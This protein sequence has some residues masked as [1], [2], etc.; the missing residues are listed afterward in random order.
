MYARR[1][2]CGQRRWGS[3]F[4]PS[5]D[6]TRPNCVDRASSQSLSRASI[7]RSRSSHNS[8]IRRHFLDSITSRGLIGGSSYSGLHG[9]LS[10]S[11]KSSQLRVYSS[12]GDG[13]NT[14]EE[15]HIPVKDGSNI[16]KGKGRREKFREDVNR[17]DAHA[18]LGEQDQREWL[19]NE[20]LAIEYKKKESPFLT[21]REKFKTEFLRRI[22][23]WEKISVS[24]ETFPYYIQ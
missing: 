9:R 2:K 6:F 10:T 7:A 15:E 16:D 21:R 22:V 19:S 24:W 11:L 5:K 1:L 23:P 4:Q 12:E 20:K 8:T 13:R 14:S 18:R 17:F 3:V